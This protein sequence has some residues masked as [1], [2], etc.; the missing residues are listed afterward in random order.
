MEETYEDDAYKGENIT[1]MEFFFVGDREEFSDLDSMVEYV[2]SH[3]GAVSDTITEKTR[4][5]VCADFDKNQSALKKIREACIPILSEN[6]FAYRHLS[7]EAYDIYDIAFE[8]E[9]QI[10]RFVLPWFEEYGLGETRIDLWKNNEWV[11]M[12]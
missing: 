8:V 4:Y 2:K 5:A 6:A 1:G 3:G 9:N 7:D 10:D 12:E 11:K